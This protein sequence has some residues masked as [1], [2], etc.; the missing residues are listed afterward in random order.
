MTEGFQI[1]A[2]QRS[3]IVLYKFDS[4]LGKPNR[5]FAVR[6]GYLYATFTETNRFQL[7]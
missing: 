4:F 5:E 2:R 3:Y 7:A 6:I 1:K